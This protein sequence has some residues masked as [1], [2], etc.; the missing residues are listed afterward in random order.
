VRQ[1][2]APGVN[3][4][5]RPDNN[6]ATEHFFFVSCCWGGIFLLLAVFEHELL[7]ANKNHVWALLGELA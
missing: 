1:S 3:G 2:E 7:H 6:F 4:A 5:R